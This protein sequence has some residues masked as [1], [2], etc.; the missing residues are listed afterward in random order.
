MSAKCVWY[1]I[2]CPFRSKRTANKLRTYIISL[3]FSSK[4]S[5]NAMLRSFYFLSIEKNGLSVMGTL[6]QTLNISLVFANRNICFSWCELYTMFL[7]DRAKEVYLLVLIDLFSNC[8][9]KKSS[10]ITCYCL[11]IRLIIFN[12][13]STHLL[14]WIYR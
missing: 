5:I 3:L 1:I 7:G 10:L 9:Y 11:I 14:L 12:I 2:Y 13:V 6:T 8:F 4:S